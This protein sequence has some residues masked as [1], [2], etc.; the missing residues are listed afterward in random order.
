VDKVPPFRYKSS[1]FSEPGIYV[2][3][4]LPKKSKYQETLYET[5]TRGFDLKKV[6][7]HF[8]NAM[9]RPLIQSALRYHQQWSQ[10]AKAQKRYF[11]SEDE[12]GI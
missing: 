8:I 1:G 6:K 5:L 2:E 7:E 11:I 12:Y 4:Y 10:F 9:K 3:L